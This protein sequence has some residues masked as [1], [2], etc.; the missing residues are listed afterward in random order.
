[1]DKQN[2]N[3]PSTLHTVRVEAEVRNNPDVEKLGRALIAIANGLPARG[4]SKEDKL[5]DN[6][7]WDNAA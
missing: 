5:H 6:E 3:H 1:M 2:T 7:R 4:L